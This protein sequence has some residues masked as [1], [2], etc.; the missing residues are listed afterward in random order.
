MSLAIE[1]VVRA[2]R[3][4]SICLPMATR[5]ISLVGSESRSIRLA[6]SFAAFVPECIATPT[7]A[8]ARAGASLVPSP[9]IA[10]SRPCSLLAPDQF[11]LRLRVSPRRRNRQDRP[12]AVM[13]R[14]VIGLSPVTITVRMPIARRRGYA[15]ADARL[16]HV[17]QAITP[18]IAPSTRHGR[19][20]APSL[21]TSSAAA[22]TP[23]G[24]DISEMFGHVS[25]DRVDGPL[26]HYFALRHVRAATCACRRRNRGPAPRSRLSS[27]LAALRAR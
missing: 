4:I 17:R 16:E 15:I 6:A 9:V 18:R 25:N 2:P 7:S 21:A 5:S 19:G 10:T 13:A 8:W 14:A 20:V 3:V 1:N 22:R 26:S 27:R 12:A 23:P 11:E 24:S